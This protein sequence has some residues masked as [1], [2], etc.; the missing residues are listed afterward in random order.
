MLVAKS[1]QGHED[2]EVGKGSEDANWRR[3]HG[4][5]A[6]S[7]IVFTPFIVFMALLA[8]GSEAAD[9]GCLRVASCPSCASCG[10]LRI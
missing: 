2:C 4:D 1:Q 10:G 6:Y 8:F 9:S 3:G 7:F 5:A